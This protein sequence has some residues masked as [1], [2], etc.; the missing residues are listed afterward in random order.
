MFQNEKSLADILRDAV[1]VSVDYIRTLQIKDRLQPAIDSFCREL[2]D[3]EY[4]S[5]KLND[6]TY[7]HFRTSLQRAIPIIT[8]DTDMQFTWKDFAK[9][10]MDVTATLSA[11]SHFDR[12]SA[13]FDNIYN[14]AKTIFNADEG[15]E[16]PIKVGQV[17][18]QPYD[19]LLDIAGNENL[20]QLKHKLYGRFVLGKRPSPFGGV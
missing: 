4:P 19:L 6:N 5:L 16:T 7:G 1:K 8:L 3:P 17:E 12:D 2:T 9:T 15:T 20:N 18:Y 11:E 13:R 10:V 14:H